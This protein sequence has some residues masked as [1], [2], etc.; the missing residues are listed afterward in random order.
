MLL[1]PML[2]KYLRHLTSG[3][4][5]LGSVFILLRIYVLM[6][7][8]SELSQHEVRSSGLVA[9]V[10]SNFSSQRIQEKY[11]L[12]FAIPSRPANV[13]L[14]NAIR[15][16]WSNTSSWSGSLSDIE[17]EHKQI[18]LMFIFGS[19]HKYDQ[20]FEQ[21]LKQ[22]DDMFVVGNLTENRI[23]LKYK[24]LWAMQ[25]SLYRYEYSY[26]IKTDD[27]IAVNLPLLIKELISRPREHFYTGN[28]R[29]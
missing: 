16:T 4:L 15:K 21:E 20:A 29:M 25:Q 12:V 24:V 3:V 22:N 26:F 7:N 10:I 23:S 9:T 13:A 19:D 5:I 6:R 18:K 27:D 8:H 14:R 17:E 28:C 1:I 2:S 11:F